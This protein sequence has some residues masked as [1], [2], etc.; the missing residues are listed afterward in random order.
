MNQ[1][2]KV[3]LSSFVSY[4]K[5]KPAR[6][7]FAQN[8]RYLPVLTPEYLR[9]N[10]G[11]KKAVVTDD[12]V[13]VNDGELILLWDGSNAGEFFR[14]KQGILASTMV[15][16]DFDAK[17]F[18][19][20]YLYY[21]LKHFEPYLKAQTRGSGVPHV[22]KEILL[23]HQIYKPLLP[24][25]SKIAE[26]LTAVDEAITQTE[27]LIAKYR[28]IKTGLMQDLLTRGIDENGRLRD[29]ATHEFKDSPLGLIPKTWHVSTLEAKKKS[30]RAYIKTGPFG[31]SL[32]RSDWVENGIPV[33]TI[34]ALGEGDFV[35]SELLFVSEEKA[36]SL[37]AYKVES[38][39][40][41]FSRVADVGR[42]TVVG[43]REHGWIMSSNL[44]RIS[45]DQSQ[46]IPW[47]AYL[48]LIHERTRTQ[49]RQSVNAG[50]REVANTAIMNDLKFAWP[51]YDEQE[52]IIEIILVYGQQEDIEV[53]DLKKLQHIK[54]GLMQDLLTGKVSVAPL[55]AGV[56]E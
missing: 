27:R 3:P 31:S 35:T 21:N 30:D 39:D 1:T 46:V 19:A 36:Q 8:G 51:P 13:L 26:V 49:I 25:Q 33:I 24:E 10:G 41:L 54:T 47:F 55:L 34:G 2:N 7:A 37:T 38:G 11:G 40:L 5:G 18:E 48:N 32:K 43:E 6:K 45:L 23:S 16:L 15:A 28:R 56:E 50:G 20:D 44:M 53:S 52:R 4:R 29:P 12:V 9:N 42:S 17:E 22:D 14:A